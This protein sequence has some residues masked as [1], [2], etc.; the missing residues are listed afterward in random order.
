MLGRRRDEVTTVILSWHSRL[1]WLYLAQGGLNDIDLDVR[2]GQ[3]RTRWVHRESHVQRGLRA[4]LQSLLL[5][6]LG[7][8]RIDALQWIERRGAIKVLVDADVLIV[9]VDAALLLGGRLIVL[10]ATGS[11][12]DFGKL[13]ELDHLR[14]AFSGHAHIVLK[15]SVEVG[16]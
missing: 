9:I 8:A 2:L 4:H 11:C 12:G 14:A 16:M 15:G 7:G 10:G 3:G 5:L 6:L 1:H 13:V